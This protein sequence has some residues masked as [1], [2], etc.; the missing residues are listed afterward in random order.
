[1]RPLEKV[2]DLPAVLAWQ[3][4]RVDPTGLFWMGAR[5]YDP[6]SGSFLSPDPLGHGECPDLYSYAHG[7]PINFIDPTG[8]G[9]A[10][11]DPSIRVNPN[12]QVVDWEGY[13]R[14]VRKLQELA[15][16]RIES[17]FAAERY[18]KRAIEAEIGVHASRV[19]RDA[20]AVYVVSNVIGYGV[21]FKSARIAKSAR[22]LINTTRTFAS[23][24]RAANLATNA[25]RTA[26]YLK[27][28]SGATFGIGVSLVKAESWSATPQILATGMVDTVA[29]VP[30][31][32]FSVEI[33]STVM[34]H[35]R[36]SGYSEEE[37]SI[38]VDNILQS[39]DRTH[40]KLVERY[41]LDSGQRI[42]LEP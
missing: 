11:G 38:V 24:G 22:E 41:G 10:R 17:Y 37:A 29:G 3:G 35:V 36:K 16:T 13:Q 31:V 27:I 20:A 30:V 33:S 8:R 6:K 32:G 18:R 40:Q 14:D 15:H 21:A 9:A 2:R 5:Y 26:N 12:G 23:I 19:V 34:D 7:D 25:Q 28:S 1:M 4:R 39:V 42:I